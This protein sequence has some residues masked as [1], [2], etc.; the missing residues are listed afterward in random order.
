MGQSVGGTNQQP[1]MNE[2]YH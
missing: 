1:S 2:S